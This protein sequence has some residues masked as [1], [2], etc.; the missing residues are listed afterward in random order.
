MTY[1]CFKFVYFID[2]I[3]DS[4]CSIQFFVDVE[5]TNYLL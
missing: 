4:V 1:V 2:C 5:L 3:F